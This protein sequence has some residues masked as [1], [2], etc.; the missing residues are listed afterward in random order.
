M[1]NQW[2]SRRDTKLLLMDLIKVL[3]SCREKG[4]DPLKYNFGGVYRK[5][6]RAKRIN[7]PNLWAKV[8]GE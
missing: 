4:V 2:L 7:L 8:R 3:R 1:K 6:P 5:Y